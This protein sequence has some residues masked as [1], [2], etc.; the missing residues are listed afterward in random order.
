MNG[1]SPSSYKT[2]DDEYPAAERNA[3]AQ[4]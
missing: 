4:N 2:E 1:G 3:M